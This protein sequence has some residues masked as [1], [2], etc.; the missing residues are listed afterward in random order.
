MS[1][2]ARNSV[3]RNFWVRLASYVLVVQ[4]GQA[5]ESIR[6]AWVYAVMTH[7]GLACLLAGMLLLGAWTGSFDVGAWRAAA[8]ALAP[9]ARDLAWAL[10]ALGFA[11][12]AGV[13]PLHVWLPLAHPAAPSHVSALMSGVM[14]K[15]GVY[16][17][18][19]VSLDWLGEG[20]AWWGAA[21]LLAGA[22]SAVVGVLSAIVDRDLKRVLA[23]S[24][25]ENVGIILIGLGAGVFCYVGIQLAKRLK[26]D[27]ALDV[28]GVHG[29][30]GMWGALATG[31]FATVAV[32]AAGAD[33]AAAGNFAQLGVQAVAVLASV[34]YSAVMTF[35]ILKVIDL[36]VGLRVP[37]HEEVLGLD[38]SQ[39]REAA[40][41]I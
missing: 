11:V 25:I 37:E 4:G 22:V 30:G 10:L 19:R 40:Y 8:S 1:W 24:S 28:F 9:S 17:L 35:A 16:G 36:F 3:V 23:F 27:D 5:R 18:V 34:S 14:I 7:A 31:I 15:L 13:I 39:H 33:G 6:A 12:K 26:V 41:Q 20:P 38:A 2:R 29:I 32:N 21:I